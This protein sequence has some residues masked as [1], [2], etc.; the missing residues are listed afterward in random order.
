MILFSKSSMMKT[1][2]KPAHPYINHILE[3]FYSSEIIS[4]Q[5]IVYKAVDAAKYILYSKSFWSSQLGV[6]VFFFS[7]IFCNVSIFHWTRRMKN[8]CQNCSSLMTSPCLF[9]SCSSCWKSSS[10]C[11]SSSCP[12][13]RQS[14]YGWPPR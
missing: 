10:C 7:L 4:P 14:S 9:R 2:F 1:L 6:V 3:S 11:P 12:V 8:P 5:L 13:L